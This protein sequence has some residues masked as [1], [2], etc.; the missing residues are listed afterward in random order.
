MLFFDIRFS[1]QSC[2]TMNFYQMLH[3]IATQA[4]APSSTSIN[5]VARVPLLVVRPMAA[6]ASFWEYGS[7]R[8]C[9]TLQNN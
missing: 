3:P 2:A 1:A 9:F 6:S 5:V 8:S 7:S 4:A